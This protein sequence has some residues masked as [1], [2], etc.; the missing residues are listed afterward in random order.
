MRRM[1]RDEADSG[2]SDEPLGEGEVVVGS[3]VGPG[4][5]DVETGDSTDGEIDGRGNATTQG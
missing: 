1:A 2:F 3:A 4:R 5:P